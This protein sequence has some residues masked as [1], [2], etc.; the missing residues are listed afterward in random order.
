MAKEYYIKSKELINK[1][2]WIYNSSSV[3]LLFQYI[4]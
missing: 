4:S 3:C 1:W 2:N